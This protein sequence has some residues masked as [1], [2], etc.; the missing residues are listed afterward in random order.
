MVDDEL[1]FRLTRPGF[2]EIREFSLDTSVLE[3]E[4]TAQTGYG[5]DPQIGPVAWSDGSDLERYEDLVPEFAKAE[6]ISPNRI[7]V[8]FHT[9]DLQRMVEEH[10][11]ELAPHAMEVRN[12]KELE[13]HMLKAYQVAY[14][15]YVRGKRN[16]G[17]SFPDKSCGISSSNVMLSLIEL[18]YTNALFVA[19]SEYDH[20]YVV[21]PFVMKD[22]GYKGVIVVDPASEQLWSE[23]SGKPRNAVF[24]REGSDWDYKTMWAGEGQELET[25]EGQRRNL[26]PETFVGLKD[27]GRYLDEEDLDPFEKLIITKMADEYGGEVEP[28]EAAYDNPVRLRNLHDAR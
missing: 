19:N 18:G 11:D 23:E 17:S 21:L 24:V 7:K 14:A 2:D 5:L 6:S 12:V 15:N 27:V 26:F 13:D 4:I 8:G 20:S 25:D 22:S 28:L 3:A 1:Y 9:I 16:Y 10:E